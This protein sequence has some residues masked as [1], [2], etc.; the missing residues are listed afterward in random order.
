[1]LKRIF[2]SSTAKEESVELGYDVCAYFVENV[3]DGTIN[4]YFFIYFGNW[5]K[6]VFN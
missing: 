3:F 2:G 1:M 4:V 5:D 6:V